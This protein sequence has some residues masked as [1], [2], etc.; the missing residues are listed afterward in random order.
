MEDTG[1]ANR[2]TVSASSCLLCQQNGNADLRRQAALLRA[3]TKM[4][5]VHRAAARQ[6]LHDPGETVVED[7]HDTPDVGCRR[8]GE[9]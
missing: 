9:G 8:C 6:S 1:D 7:A 3:T 4:A 2:S 5:L